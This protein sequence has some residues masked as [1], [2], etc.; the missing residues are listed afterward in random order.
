[1]IVGVNRYQL[2]G[3]LEVETLK[4]DAALEHKQVERVRA[5]RARR[6]SGA[7]EAALARL[8]EDAARDDRNLMEPILDAARAYVTMGEMCDALRGVWGVWRETPVF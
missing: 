4:I 7:V 6:D 2:E 5:L 8:K 1:M 3:E